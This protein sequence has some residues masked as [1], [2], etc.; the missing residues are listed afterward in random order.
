MAHRTRAK[1]NLVFSATY[2]LDLH[3]TITIYCTSPFFYQ[4]RSNW[5]FGHYRTL[6]S[7]LGGKIHYLRRYRNM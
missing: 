4:Q 6:K 5:L 3:N 7:L 2:Y 1:L